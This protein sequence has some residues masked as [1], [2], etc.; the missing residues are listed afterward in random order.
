MKKNL[1]YTAFS[2]VLSAVALTSCDDFLDKEPDERTEIDTESKIIGLMVDAYPWANP[3]SVCELMGDNLVDNNAPHNQLDNNGRLLTVH[4]NLN[5]MERMDDELFLFEPVRSS[6]SWDSPSWLWQAYYQSVAVA[7]IALN[8]IEEYKANGGVETEKLKSVKGEALLVRAFSHFMLVNIFSQAYKNPEL[9]K[10]DV[11]VPYVTEVIDKVQVDYDRGNVADVYEKIEKDLEEGLSLISDVHL[12]KPKWHF[13]TRAAHAFAARFYLFKRD[14]QKVIEHANA[15]LGTDVSTI[16]P[17]LFNYGGFASLTTYAAYALAY[18]GSEVPNNLML[19]VTNS[20]HWRRMGGYGYKNRYTHNADAAHATVDRFGPTWDLSLLPCIVT[21]GLFT[22][23][24]QDYGMVWARQLESF[25]YSDKV[26][27]I[28]TPHVVRSEFTCDVLLLERAEAKIMLADT[29]GALE[30][31]NALETSRH[32]MTSYNNAVH[33]L[34]LPVV[35]YYYQYPGDSG[36]TYRNQRSAQVVAQYGD[37]SFTQNMSPDFVVKPE[38]QKWMNCLMDYRRIETLFD[39]TRFFDL[40]RFGIEYS[41]VYGKDAEEHMLTWNDP[42]RAVEVPQEVLAS[43]L[44]SSRTSATTRAVVPTET[45][46]QSNG[47][48]SSRITYNTNR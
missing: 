48:F 31:L 35:Q 32:T 46:Q 3:A 36:E 38:L 17:L 47:K 44:Q 9:S 13:N 43:G 22:T 25:E 20:I 28:G 6:T 29:L 27:G 7:N 41:H 8:A 37:W 34:S 18:Q 11:G 40:K 12:T 4:Y 21:S 24:G 33:D 10:A 23:G 26:A 16:Q 15:V 2:V 42:R 39:G 1:L 19:L 45:P 5:S 30:D 14:Y